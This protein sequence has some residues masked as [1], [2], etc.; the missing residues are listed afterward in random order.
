MFSCLDE[1]WSRG[2]LLTPEPRKC[3]AKLLL[4]SNCIS[5]MQVMAWLEPTSSWGG[6]SSFVPCLA[7]K[8]EKMAGPWTRPALPRDEMHLVLKSKMCGTDFSVLSFSLKAYR[9][10]FS[11]NSNT[12]KECLPSSCLDQ[13]S[14]VWNPQSLAG[15][16]CT[17]ECYTGW[18]TWQNL[19]RI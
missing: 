18:P 5:A 1:L 17:G 14:F 12:Q 4:S 7:P 9:G 11:A 19:F 15:M 10:S 6:F 2:F 16:F 8:L 3:K 13:V